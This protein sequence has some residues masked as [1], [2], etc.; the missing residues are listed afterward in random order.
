MLDMSSGLTVFGMSAHEMSSLIF[1]E[2]IY[3]KKMRKSSAENVSFTE[4]FNQH[5]RR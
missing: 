1:S 2:K 3:E 4:I 5:A